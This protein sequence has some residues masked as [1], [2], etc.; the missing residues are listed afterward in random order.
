MNSIDQRLQRLRA[1]SQLLD[2]QKAEYLA[3]YRQQMRALRRLAKLAKNG[4]EY[5]GGV[6]A[7]MGQR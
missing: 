5:A 1:A 3:F 2:K 4:N 6:L 7:R